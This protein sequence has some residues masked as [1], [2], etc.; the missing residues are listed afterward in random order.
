ME[1][2][3]ALEFEGLN[4]QAARDRHGMSDVFALAEE[5]YR[6]VPRRPAEPEPQADPWRAD[7]FRPVLHGLL[8]GLPTM[9]FPAS[10]ELIAGRGMLTEVF[11]ASLSQAAGM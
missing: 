9:F 3:S 11:S 1:I 7:F 10:A 2:C 8:Y 6:R 5:M 4:D